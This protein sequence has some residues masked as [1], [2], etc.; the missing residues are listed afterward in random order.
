MIWDMYK[1]NITKYPTISSLSFAIF[2]AHFLKKDTV[3]MI[4]GQ[5]SLRKDIMKEL[6]FHKF[7]ALF[8]IKIVNS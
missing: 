3:P 8:Y 7:Y 1:L 4:Y 6:N 2:R 5:V